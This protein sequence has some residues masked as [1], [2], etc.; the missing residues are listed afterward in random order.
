MFTDILNVIAFLLSIET[1]TKIITVSQRVKELEAN[2]EIQVVRDVHRRDPERG[3][4]EL[5]AARNGPGDLHAVLERGR[6]LPRQS[7]LRHRTD[8]Q[9]L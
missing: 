8:R 9:K 7:A 6:H 2:G 1:W 4:E 5:P 3:F